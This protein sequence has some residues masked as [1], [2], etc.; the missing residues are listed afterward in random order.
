MGAVSEAPGPMTGSWEMPERGAVFTARRFSGALLERRPFPSGTCRALSAFR[1]C[2]LE[3]GLT[4]ESCVR[5][6]R[7]CGRNRSGDSSEDSAD[8][9]LALLAQITRS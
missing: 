2:P 9:P 5:G 3:G 1:F 6:G 4:G 8:G 7:W